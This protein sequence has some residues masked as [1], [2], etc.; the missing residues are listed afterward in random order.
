MWPVGL[1]TVADIATNEQQKSAH[2]TREASKSGQYAV[3]G[4]N[5]RRVTESSQAD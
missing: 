3:C 2:G 5:W 4:E 1:P